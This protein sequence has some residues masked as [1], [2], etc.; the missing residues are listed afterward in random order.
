MA[1]INVLFFKMLLLCLHQKSSY[2]TI[3]ISTVN[4]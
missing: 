3:I 1:S 2:Q 4:S